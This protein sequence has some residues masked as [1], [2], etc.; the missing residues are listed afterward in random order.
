MGFGKVK[1]TDEALETVA[2]LFRSL[3]EATRLKVLRLLEEQ[4]MSVGELAQSIKTSQANISKHLKMLLNAGVLSRRA[5]GTAAYYSIADP[6][7]YQICD[8]I[9]DGMTERMKKQAAG[10]GLKVKK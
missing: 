6:M 3:G 8:T 2:L 9:C 1:L 5:Q 4:E 7:I 10:F